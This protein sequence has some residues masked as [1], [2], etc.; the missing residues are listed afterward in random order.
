MRKVFTRFATLIM[1]VFTMAIIAALPMTAFAAENE[2]VVAVVDEAPVYE[3]DVIYVQAMANT[4]DEPVIQQLG[5]NQQQQQAA[6]A[7]SAYENTIDFFITWIR[8]VGAAIAFIGAIM[9]ALAI[10]NDDAER[11]Q[12]G[13]MT[14]AAGFVVWAVCA[15]ADMFDLFT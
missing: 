11:K 3:D 1:A 7:D 2:A 9:F 10:K 13:L 15:A 5:N 14:L 12:A 4:Y 8:R 6:T